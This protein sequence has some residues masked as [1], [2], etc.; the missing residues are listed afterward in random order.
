[1]MEF[2]FKV[3]KFD[4]LRRIGVREVFHATPLIVEE[5]QT[6]ASSLR[7]IASLLEDVADEDT[8]VEL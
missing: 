2:L 7:V 1:M 3:L 5:L 8:D 4:L 6:I